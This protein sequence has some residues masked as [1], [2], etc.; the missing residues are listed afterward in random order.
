V[1]EV[2]PAGNHRLTSSVGLV[3]LLLLG[4]EALTTLALHSYLSLHIFLGLLLLP[5]LAI[6]L[7]STGWRFVRYYTG[8]TH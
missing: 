3:L 5:P 1:S 6:K 7:A 2:G 4:V 8:S